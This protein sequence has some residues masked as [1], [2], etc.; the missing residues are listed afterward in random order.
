[1]SDIQVAGSLA[2]GANSGKTVR[3]LQD[4]LQWWQ[5]FTLH[6]VGVGQQDMGIW[7]PY[8]CYIVKLR[9]RIAVA[10]T[11]GS[12]TAQLQTSP[13]AST[14][15][16]SGTS[17]TPSTSPSWTTPTGPGISMN[18]DDMVWCY[19]TAI[20]STTVGAQLKAEMILERR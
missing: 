7:L 14:G 1:M 9:Y 2:F 3:G 6:A 5:T 16:I 20:N 12:L 15:V 13:L 4:G 17:A 19:V 10:G 18:A 11:G 8:N